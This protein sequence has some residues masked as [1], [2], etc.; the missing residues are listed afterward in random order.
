MIE[1][2][3][4]LLNE[5]ISILQP[6]SEAG[7][8]RMVE[9]NDFYHKYISAIQWGIENGIFNNKYINIFNNKKCIQITGDPITLYG[10]QFLELTNKDKM[11]VH[12]DESVENLTSNRKIDEYRPF[13]IK[14]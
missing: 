12:T 13:E 9:D 3:K 4:K 11:E 6:W 2:Y 1:N 14:K 8:W 10:Y 7:K 5:F